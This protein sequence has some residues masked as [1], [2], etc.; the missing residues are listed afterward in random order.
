MGRSSPGLG[1]FLQTLEDRLAALS[2]DEVREALLA[3]AERL[4]AS[5][6]EGFLA[7][8][9]PPGRH[10]AAGKHPPAES[11]PSD[12]LLRDIDRFVEKARSGDY[13]E[14]WGWDDDI[15]DERAFGDESWVQDLDDLFA[16]AGEAFVGGDLALAREA[17]GRLLHAFLLEEDMTAYPGPLPASDMLKT[18]VG[19]GKARYLRA[20]Y[21]TTPL[22]DRAASL[23]VEMR[24]LRYVGPPATL[25]ALV[26]ARRQ[27]LPDMKAFLSA[28]IARL[29][30]MAGAWPDFG[31]EAR[32]LLREA[33]QLEGGIDGLADLARRQGQDD[34][35]AFRE[36]MTALLRAGRTE[37]A[38]AAAREALDRL[39]P[40]GEVRARIADG[41]AILA[42]AQGD[43]ELSL[44]ARRE[45]WR[46]APS[47]ARL[48][49]LHS[50]AVERGRLDEVMADEAKLVEAEL[51]SDDAR[52]NGGLKPPIDPRVACELLLLAGRVDRACAVLMAAEPLGWSHG[53]HPGPL[54]VPY[55][56][57]AGS[58]HGAPNDGCPVLRDL[59]RA[60]DDQLGAAAHL[61]FDGSG[62]G[63]AVDRA[64]GPD[65]A[66][67]QGVPPGLS[68][69]FAAHLARQV[70]A[71]E[72]QQRWLAVGEA[73]VAARTTAVVEG[74]H[75]SAYGQVARLVVACAEALALAGG[76]RDGARFLDEARARYPRHYGFRRELDA[77]T[78]RSPLLPHPPRQRR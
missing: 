68:T 34:P 10:V 73:A 15:H 56:L 28:W 20:L 65:D 45:A 1:P 18:D 12:P 38:I 75:R 41:L 70:P 63:I 47:T 14:G 42:T 11:D 61:R 50:A 29:E 36:W 37:E 27:P 53:R 72:E 35:E 9:P 71:P 40:R 16:D 5:D 52:P 32:R 78:R 57:A 25:Q 54:V 66:P 2:P 17:Y 44:D 8:F 30:S 21:E 58:G 62:V 74:Q 6:R 26:E 55:L 49:E 22:Q 48:V 60:M 3:H 43:P 46:A 67:D 77:V 33:V 13:V 19:E 7:M 51:A 24:T 76:S 69:V 31:S 39:T 64:P 23:V 59:F 4:P